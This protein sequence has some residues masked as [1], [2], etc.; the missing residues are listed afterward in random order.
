MSTLFSENTIPRVSGS[1]GRFTITLENNERGLQLLIRNE[2]TGLLIVS[3]LTES[4]LRDFY[5]LVHEIQSET[6]RVIRNK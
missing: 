4:E 6:Y 1:L 2:I 3:Q 5:S